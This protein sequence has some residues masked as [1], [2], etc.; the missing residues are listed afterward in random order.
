MSPKSAFNKK[1]SIKWLLFVF[2]AL[3]AIQ[4]FCSNIKY[5]EKQNQEQQQTSK[6]PEINIIQRTIRAIKSSIV[7]ETSSPRL[8][9]VTFAEAG[10]KKKK[11]K[12]EVVVISVNNPS[13]GHGGMYPIYIPTCGGHGG[14]YGRRKRSI[15]SNIGARMAGKTIA[16]SQDGPSNNF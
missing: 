9:G 16:S 4:L 1:P 15:N 2:W 8:F 13:K 5:Q 14:G 3:V 6:T 12:S 10:K 7:Q 11:E